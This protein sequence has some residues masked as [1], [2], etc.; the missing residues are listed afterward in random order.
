MKKSTVFLEVV[1]IG[2]LAVG[3]YFVVHKLS[4]K[5]VSAPA[6]G[7]TATGSGTPAQSTSQQ[8][9]NAGVQ[10]GQKAGNELLG[11]LFGSSSNTTQTNSGS[12]TPVQQQTNNTPVSTGLSFLNSLGL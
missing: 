5:A 4:Q 12:G 10:L 1:A 3:G 6:S 7:T 11:W 2:V 8:L 9:Q